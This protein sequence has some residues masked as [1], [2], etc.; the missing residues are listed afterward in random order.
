MCKE[1]RTVSQ[2]HF[3]KGIIPIASLI[4]FVEIDGQIFVAYLDPT[5]K[6]V[7]VLI[8]TTPSPSLASMSTSSTSSYF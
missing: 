4:D 5:A 3:G 1:S 7:S 8:S 6:L 2:V